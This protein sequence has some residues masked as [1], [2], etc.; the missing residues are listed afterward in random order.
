MCVIYVY[1]HICSCVGGAVTLSWDASVFCHPRQTFIHHTRRAF[2]WIRPLPHGMRLGRVHMSANVASKYKKPV[3]TQSSASFLEQIQH[4]LTVIVRF[5]HI[6]MRTGSTVRAHTHSETFTNLYCRVSS[7]FNLQWQ[8]KSNS[9]KSYVV[10]YCNYN[11]IQHRNSV[12]EQNY[13]TYSDI[14]VWWSYSKLL[15]IWHYVWILTMAIV[16]GILEHEQYCPW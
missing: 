10:S 5:V 2:V 4:G 14:I 11:S 13:S 9:N 8:A 16:G 1:V 3:W 7:L 15:I 12:T 6:A